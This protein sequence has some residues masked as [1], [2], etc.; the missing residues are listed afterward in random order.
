MLYL[1]GITSM[2]FELMDI[3]LYLAIILFATKCC[4]LLARKIGL[5]QAA[6][7]VLAGLL[8]GPAIFSGFGGSFKGLIN[9]SEVE[10]DVLA[11]FSQVGVIFI[12]FSSGLETNFDNLKK[13]GL[14]ATVIAILGVAVPMALGTFGT[15]L[16]MGGFTALADHGTLMNCLFVGAILT[17]TSVGITV[18]T[19]RELGKLNTKLGTT[20]LS[21]A[22]IDDVIGVIVLSIV[23][24][25]DGKGSVLT[26][27]LKALG[28]F[29]FSVGV[30]LVI[31][32][33]FK[34]M[35]KRNPHT[36]R[37][38]IFSLVTCMLYAYVAEKFF[39]IAAITGAFM[40]GLMISGMPDTPYVDRK[41]VVSGYMIFT[42]IFFAYIGI[43]A[44]FSNFKPS[45]LIF[46]AVFVILGIIG[47]IIGCSGAAKMFKY[48]NKEALTTG[49]GMV[50]RGEVAL[51]VY[52]T[53]KSLVKTGASG[54]VTG[55]DPL[56][57]TI[58]LIIV[59]SI[60]CPVFLKIL[61]KDK[62]EK[63]A[64]VKVA[65]SGTNSVATN[66][67]ENQTDASGK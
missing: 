48:S 28:F 23:T 38:G 12:L 17:A 45:D 61:F 47:K 43:S 32:K 60:V 55:V 40:A 9:P 30:G 62:S 13:S 16:F 1:R 31:R 50:A 18:E 57:A 63:G 8:I 25:L 7:M 65:V 41:V 26:T 52:S 3:V 54:E 51:A 46:C 29:I 11:S 66:S 39:G 34:A 27:L 35:E 67:V 24:S 33:L 42:P 4:G 56:M 15:A 2:D 64:A 58:M 5:P 20:I 22:I 44:D 59:T 53:G 19:L 21:A 6:G 49:F 14:A 37:I 10:M 36:R